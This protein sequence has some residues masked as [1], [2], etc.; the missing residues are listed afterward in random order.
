MDQLEPVAVLA[1][2]PVDTGM[3]VQVLGSHGLTGLAFPLAEDPWQQTAFQLAAPGEKAAAVR[4]VLAEAA[5]Q[6]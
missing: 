6:G 5:R 3:G 1:G 2:T 4:S